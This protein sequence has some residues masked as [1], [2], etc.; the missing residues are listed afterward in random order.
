MLED[1]PRI[2]ITMENGVIQNICSTDQIE[3]K[4]LNVDSIRLG[5]TLES[6]NVYEPDTFID[7][8][9][10]E[11]IIFN[12]I[13]RFAMENINQNTL[14]DLFD[15][16]NQWGNK[17][18]FIKPEYVPKQAMKVIEEV[19]EL[20]SAIIKNKSEKEKKDGV[21]DTLVTV[22]ILCRQLGFDPKECL[23]LAMDEIRNRDV[24]MVNG[25]LIKKED[26]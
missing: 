23:Q 26:R 2:L 10:M 15:E 13:E 17:H 9:D 22:I 4:I 16:V 20:F 21:G 5:D 6:R 8:E 7:K 3:I 24:K 12:A 18:E 19:G 25:S 14:D 11:K 1:T